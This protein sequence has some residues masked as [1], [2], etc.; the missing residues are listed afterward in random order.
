M[1]C[2]IIPETQKNEM[3]FPKILSNMI[4]L[5]KEVGEKKKTTTHTQLTPESWD[6]LTDLVN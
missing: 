1:N 6:L 2:G 4:F 5:Y 3:T